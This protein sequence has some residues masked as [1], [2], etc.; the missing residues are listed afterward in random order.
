PAEGRDRYLNDLV[1]R[2]AAFNITWMGVPAFE[3]LTQGR[4]A[5]KAIYNLI[6]QFDPY[7]HPRT[8]MARATSAPLSDDGWLD[9]ISYGTV[10]PNVGAVEHQFYQRP[11]VN[12][13]IQ[14]RSDL[15]NATMNGQYPSAGSGS[16][17]AAWFDFMSGNRYW[18][19]EPYFD[20]KGGR[21]L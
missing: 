16:H 18:D 15:W 5:L 4:P 17:M 8:S 19:M 21:A 11:A 1:S 12:T 14:S 6:R 9:L 10:D 3:E 20:V 2:F 13:A 7:Q